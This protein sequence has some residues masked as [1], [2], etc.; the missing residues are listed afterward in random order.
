MAL[1]CR[2]Q[3]ADR[4]DPGWVLGTFVSIEKGKQAVQFTVQDLQ[5]CAEIR[6]LAYAVEARC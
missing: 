5:S 3:P 2:L 1:E 4:L 6:T